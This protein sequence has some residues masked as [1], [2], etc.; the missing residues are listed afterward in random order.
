MRHNAGASY[1]RRLKVPFEAPSMLSF[2][3][4]GVAPLSMLSL[5]RCSARKA[6]QAYA[7]RVLSVRLFSAPFLT[8]FWAKT[9]SAAFRE[10]V[11]AG[12]PV[13]AHRIL[14]PTGIAIEAVRMWRTREPIG[15]ERTVLRTTEGEL[16][17][18]V[19]ESGQCGVLAVEVHRIGLFQAIASGYERHHVRLFA[20]KKLVDRLHDAVVDLECHQI[21]CVSS[22]L[23]MPKYMA[24]VSLCSKMT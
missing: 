17:H 5:V 6:R 10:G 9:D 24:H 13:H 7:T 2:G 11:E 22:A 23:A 12:A 20:F 3:G 4:F 14:P 1:R 18:P 19:P 16:V 8:D 21:G 15:A